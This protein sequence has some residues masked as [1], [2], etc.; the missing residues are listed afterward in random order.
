MVLSCEHPPPTTTSVEV[1]V[2]VR[3]QSVA[4][5]MPVLAGNVLAVHSMVISAGQMIAGGVRSLTIMVWI[6]LLELPQSSIATHVRVI[7]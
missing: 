3:S 5:A 4:V 7:V 6:Q 1:M 2:G